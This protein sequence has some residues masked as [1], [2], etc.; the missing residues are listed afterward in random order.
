MFKI[1]LKSNRFLIFISIIL[2]FFLM[3]LT[4]SSLTSVAQNGS[5]ENL[6]PVSNPN[7]DPA[8][9]PFSTKVPTVRVLETVYFTGLE[10]YDPNPED[11]LTYHWNF[12][13]GS[14]SNLASPIHVFHQIGEYIVSLTVNDTELSNTNKLKL[15]VMSEGNH[16]PVVRIKTN[17]KKDNGNYIANISE[18]I[19]FDA[20][21]SYDPERFPLSFKWDF[22][23]GSISYEMI[24]THEYKENGNYTVNLTA[25]DHEERESTAQIFIKIGT[26][27]GGGSKKNQDSSEDAMSL[28]WIILAVVIVIVILL[29]IT[30]LFLGYLRRRTISRAE[31]AAGREPGGKPKP[32][33]PAFAR[34]EIQQR[35]RLSRLGRIDQLAK[36]EA[37]VKQAIMREKL[38]HERKKVDD[39]MK[40]ELEDMGIEI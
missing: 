15:F 35:E 31:L 1:G 40:K 9:H 3:P 27:V 20:S 19:N 33:T 37:Q 5:S 17:A 11:N 36:S 28:G 18:A 12:G 38:Q 7:L 2:F 39:D 25:F 29:I 32:P 26:G 13:D 22:G 23:D 10:S 30:W 34:R 8:M 4:L 21:E 6:P 14:T 16:D 24:T